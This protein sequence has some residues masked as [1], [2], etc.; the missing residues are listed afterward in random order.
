MAITTTPTGGP[1]GEFSTYTPISAQTLSGSAST[2]TFSN[3]PSNYTDLVLVVTGRPTSAASLYIRFNNDASSIYSY[4]SLD[5]GGSGSP[6]GY[7]LSGNT[8][9]TYAVWRTTN[10]QYAVVQ[11]QNYSSNSIHKSFISRSYD[12]NTTNRLFAGLYRSTAAISRIDFLIDTSYDTGCTFTLYGI[13]AATPA[14]KATG[15][16]VVSTDGAYWYHAF[17]T[18]GVFTADTSLTADILVVAGGGSGA[19]GDYASSGGGAG[20]LVGLSSQ[21]L[22]PA[23]YPVVVGAGGAL[24]QYNTGNGN[25]GSNSRFGALTAAVGGG[26][27]GGYAIPNAGDGSNGNAGG[28]GGGGSYPGHTGGAKTSGQGNV[29]GNANGAAPGY[30]GG[31]GGGAGAAG[32]TPSGASNPAPGGVGATYNTT[33]DGTG[34]FAFINPMGAASGTGQVVSGNY[35]YA[36]GGGGGGYISTTGAAGGYGGGGTGQ[37]A[38]GGAAGFAGTANTGGGGGGSGQGGNPGSGG[39]GVVIVRYPV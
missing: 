28:S 2:V 23:A 22:S 31:G 12:D 16:D 20:G 5:S 34:P 4:T 25:N 26:G 3:I 8:S 15:G 38:G 24:K 7:R 17:K 27:A 6:A 33:V 30:P 37:G 13:K 19:G 18:T 39:S 14:P 35:Y 1:Q 10:T 32:S 29:G 36:G 9:T 21:S 11:I